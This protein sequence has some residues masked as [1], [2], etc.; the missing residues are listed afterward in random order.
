MQLIRADTNYPNPWPDT[1]S[2]K[3]LDFF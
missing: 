2:S 3:I 1:S